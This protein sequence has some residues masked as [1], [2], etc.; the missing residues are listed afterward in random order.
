[1]GGNSDCTY[2]NRFVP[3]IKTAGTE[4]P[5]RF[6]ARFKPKIANYNKTLP[7]KKREMPM[8][9]AASIAQAKGY[10]KLLLP[11]LA[12]SVL[13][14]WLITVAFQLLLIDIAQTFEVQVGTASMM[15]SVGSISGVV[16]G[17]LMAFLSVKYNHKLFLL[18]GLSLTILAAIGFY[19]APNFFVLMISNIGVGGG[20][21]IVTAMAYS[22]IGD[23]YPLEKRGRAIGATVASVALAFVV[24]SPIVG[25]IATFGDWRSVMILLSLPFTIVS[26][27]LAAFVVPNRQKINNPTDSESFYSGCKQAFSGTATVAALLVTVFMFCE[28][29]IGYYSVSFF[30]EYFGMTI[31][32]GS[33]FILVGNLI[34]AVGGAV[35]GLLVNRVG[36]KRL[37]TVTLIVAGLLTLLFTFMPTVE[38]S[39]AL[40]IVRFWFSSMT[41][42]AGGALIIEQL[43]RFR[44]TMMSLNTAFMNVGM[45]LASLIAGLML[46][47]YGYQAVGVVLGSLGILGAVVW[48]AFVKEPVKKN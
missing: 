17:L 38:F 6:Y 20:I 21:A 14:T 24:G 1:M 3:L 33:I 25:I 42:T 37:G 44:S 13:S 15:A 43:P 36:R 35:A 22:I 11:S 39:A 32:W 29:A 26:L 4:I 18:I 31:S 28:S 9:Q 7:P 16:F 46:N 40:N 47:V 23:V 48:I 41:F 5:V 30:R 34:G 2:S 10:S 8:T 45:L 12:L 19:F 27:G